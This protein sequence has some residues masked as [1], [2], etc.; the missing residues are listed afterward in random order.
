[1]T[2]NVGAATS[3]GLEWTVGWS[4][5]SGLRLSDNGAYT[6]A[7]LTQDAPLLGGARG[8]VLA[9][10]PHWS[11]NLNIDYEWPV[12]SDFSA[13]TGGSWTY[14]GSRYGDFAPAGT[15]TE[16]H[17]KLPSYSTFNLQLGVKDKSY[18]LE[19]YGRN[20]TDERGISSYNNMQGYNQTGLLTLIQ[21][22]TIGLR[23][24]ATY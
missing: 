2:G 4:P 24:A 14:T 21:P 20:L 12:F 17:P 10:V 18:T 1:V 23:V 16:D 9:Y 5:L 13:F 22:R 7:H 3:R 6:D 19:L 11:N 15:T 8:D